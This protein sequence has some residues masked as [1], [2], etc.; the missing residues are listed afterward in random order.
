LTQTG[1]SQTE[2]LHCTSPDLILAIRYDATSLLALT[3][4]IRSIETTRVH[5]AARRRGCVVGARGARAAAGD[6]GGRLPMQRP[7]TMPIAIMTLSLSALLFMAMVAAKGYA[8][9]IYPY[10]PPLTILEPLW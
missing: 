3:D 1:L 10:L 6:A 2:I 5:H 4:A 7:I 9:T 8:I